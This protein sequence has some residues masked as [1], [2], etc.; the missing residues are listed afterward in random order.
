MTRTLLTILLSFFVSIAFAQDRVVDNFFNDV[1]PATLT[2][3]SKKNIRATHY[4]LIQIDLNQLYAEL[5]SVPH[6]DGLKSGVAT[7][8]RLPLPDGSSKLYQI[9][10]NS[11]LHP[12]LGAKYPTIKTYDAYGITDPGEFVK[13]DLTAQGFHSMIFRPGKSPV[14]IDPLKDGKH[15]YYMIYKKKDFISNNHFKCSMQSVNLGIRALTHSSSFAQFNACQLK[16]YRLA[17]A[18]TAQYTQFYGGTINGALSAQ[19][20]TMNRVNGIYELD[21]AITMQIIA[22]NDQIIFTDPNTQPYT[23][24]DPTK[25]ITENQITIDRIIGSPNYDIGHVVDAAG[26]GLAQLRSVCN[27]ESKAMG[28]T[29]KDSPIND[30]FDVDYVAHEMGHQF[31]AAHVQNNACYRNQPTAVEPGSGSTIMGYAG[32]CPPN[33]QTNSDSYFNGISLKQM[34]D[35]V[36]SPEHNCPVTTPISSA[37]VIH[38]TNGDVSIP[39]QTPF[40][41]TALATPGSAGSVITYTWEQMDNEISPQPPAG[42]SRGGP[43]FRSFSPQTSP[44]RYFPKLSALTNGG[45][46]TWEVLSSVSRV[47]NFKV[48]VRANTPGGS[49]NAYTDTRIM[50]TD[51]AGP[52]KVTN[53]SAA[54]IQ[55]AGQSLQTIN[56]DVANTNV[57]PVSMPLVNVLLSTDGGAS[58]PIPLVVGASNNGHADICVPNINTTTARVMIQASNGTFFNISKNNFSIFATPLRAPVL[59]KA[60]RNRMNTKEAFI[61]YADCLPSSNIAYTVNGLPGATIRL[62][63]QH[64]RFIIS[65]ILTPKRVHNVTITAV[66]E[67]NVSRTSNPIT[68]PSIL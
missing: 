48:S 6:R 19:A 53:P 18:A 64:H 41:L 5:E 63:L 20:T 16:T 42:T 65:N 45:P 34:G 49:C 68:I 23:S 55:W 28:T 61:L 46:F 30:P 51:N 1:N 62:D 21:M 66:D 58:Y 25:L 59:T 15:Q 8:I 54:N 2:A 38:Q 57:F 12:E 44:T 33:V 9:V 47:M 60:D 26:S 31:G 11:T 3:Q 43:N 52:F 37:P 29:G 24:G 39:A 32:I 14:F 27:N 13:L 7:Q 56:W 40:A 22:N 35:F 67:S 36:S 10:E 50:I 4:R 17:M